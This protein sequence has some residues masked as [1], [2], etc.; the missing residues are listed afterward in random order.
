MGGPN[1]FSTVA[2]AGHTNVGN[3]CE[4]GAPGCICDPGE[5]GGSS[6]QLPNQTEKPSHQNASPIRERTSFDFGAGAL[7]LALVFFVWTRLR[8]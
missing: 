4:C 6:R 5:L 7:M 1:P 8:A 2:L 3:W